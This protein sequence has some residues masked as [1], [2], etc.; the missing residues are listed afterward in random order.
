MSGCLAV[1]TAELSAAFTVATSSGLHSPSFRNS[2]DSTYFGWG[3]GTWDGNPPQAPGDPDV[4]PDITNGT[5]SIHPNS[6]GLITQANTADLIS[7]SNNIYSSVTG[8]N[9]AG[10]QL[11]I[12]T[13]GTLSLSGFTT[14]IIQGYGLSGTNFG[15]GALDGLGFGAINGVAPDYILTGN[16]D[17]RGQWWAKWELSGSQPSYSVDITGV[18]IGSTPFAVSVTDLTVDTFVSQSGFAPDT[19]IVPEPSSLFLLVSS[20]CLPLLNRRRP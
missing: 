9:A 15:V 19:A 4:T 13:T 6:G 16:A 10:L 11:T 2:A 8:I 5:P 17:S 7:G 3:A 20:L 18:Q 14:I 1:T 12:P